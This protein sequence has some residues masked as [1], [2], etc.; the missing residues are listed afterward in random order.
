MP[1]A[2]LRSRSSRPAC[3]P[4]RAAPCAHRVPPRTRPQLLRAA[5]CPPPATTMPAIFA[6]ANPLSLIPRLLFPWFVVPCCS[7]FGAEKSGQNFGGLLPLRRG[8]AHLLVASL[9]Q[10][11]E[12]S[13]PIVLRRSPM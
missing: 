7:S 1:G 2:A 3:R 9:G 10:F 6:S 11:I 13:L 4:P 5:G 12:L 8:L